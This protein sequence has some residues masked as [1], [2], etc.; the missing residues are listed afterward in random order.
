M[1]KTVLDGLVMLPLGLLQFLSPE[2][3]KVLQV[4]RGVFDSGNVDCEKRH[5]WLQ[6]KCHCYLGSVRN[7]LWLAQHW[8]PDGVRTS[9]AIF[10]HQ[11]TS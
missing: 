6:R 10:M 1:N 5:A 4:L 7:A 8:V 2:Y 11:L 9:L 3:H